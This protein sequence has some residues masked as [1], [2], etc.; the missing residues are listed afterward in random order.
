MQ[1]NSQKRDLKNRRKKNDIKQAL[2]S[3]LFWQKVFDMDFPQK[4]F[5]GVFELPL[6]LLGNAQKNAIKKIK[7]ID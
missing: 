4:V 1:R 2:F 5:W 6:F 7:K 3:R